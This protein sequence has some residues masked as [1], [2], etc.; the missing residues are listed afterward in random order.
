MKARSSAAWWK[1]TP[2]APDSYWGAR[3]QVVAADA[4]AYNVGDLVRVV[5][6]DKAPATRA[7]PGDGSDYRIGEYARIAAIDLGTD[8]VSVPLGLFAHAQLLTAQHKF[9]QSL[10]V[11]DSLAA[12]WPQSPLGDDI[13]YERFRI[14]QARHLFPEAAEYLRRVV[15]L[16][17]NDILVD[18][19][20]FDLGLLYEG[21]LNDK[22]KALE[23]FGK[24]LFEQSGS[25]YTTTARDHYRHLRGDHD[26][27]D[28]PEQKFL[29]GP[30]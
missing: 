9:T 5:S 18:N 1:V 8:T 25:I 17:P 6:D 11:L 22:A 3:K 21:P 16:Y 10:A 19:A 14:A 20:M 4:S 23:W 27:L 30:Q 26:Q 29:N 24:L 15:E 12:A 2:P 28:T 13:L 7:T